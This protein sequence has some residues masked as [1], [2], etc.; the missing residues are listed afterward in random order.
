MLIGLESVVGSEVDRKLIAKAHRLH[1]AG[2]YI[3]GEILDARMV[4]FSIVKAATGARPAHLIAPIGP[5]LPQA[6]RHLIL[7]FQPPETAPF[8]R[9]WADR[10][11][12]WRKGRRAAASLKKTD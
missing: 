6:I 11:R 8:W 2:Y 3:E 9:R 7:N 10:L 5:G 12:R 1:R 4:S